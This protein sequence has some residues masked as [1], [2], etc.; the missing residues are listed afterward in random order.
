MCELLGN[1][2]YGSHEDELVKGN[3][4]NKAGGQSRC[5][6]SVVVVLLLWIGVVPEGLLTFLASLYKEV[7]KT[8]E[9]LVYRFERQTAT[10][11]ICLPSKNNESST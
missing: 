9:T 5:S 4:G 7:A 11:K 3:G 1:L 10:K 8:T 6:S 2:P